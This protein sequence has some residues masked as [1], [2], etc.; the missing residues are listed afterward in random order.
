MDKNLQVYNSQQVVDWYRQL[1]QIIPVEEKIFSEWKSLLAQ[2]K[3]LDMGIGG[4]RTT[5]YLLER[6]GSY[7]GIDYS[8]N[9]VNSV[10]KEFP[11]ANC[12]VMDARDLSA[13]DNNAFDFVNFSFNGMDYADLEG[14][15]KTLREIHRVLKPGGIFFFSTHNRDHKTFHLL[16]WLNRANGLWVNFKTFVKL[17]PFLLRKKRLAK[18]EIIEKDYAVINDSAHQFSLMTF[19]TSL[20]FLRKQLSDSGFYDHSFYL[21]SGEKTGDA[22]LGDWIFVTTRKTGS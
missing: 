6:C 1:R 14:R 11:N 13:F 9:F 17:S 12:L 10:K 19:Y 3:V 16:P 4:G 21:D 7:T 22:E 15:K 2:G 5:A 18:M 8:E 20:S